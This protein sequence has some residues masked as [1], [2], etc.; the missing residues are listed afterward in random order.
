MPNNKQSAKRMRQDAIRR[1]ANRGRKSN[2]KTT[3]RRVTEAKEA[4]DEAAVKTAMNAA[5]KA[6][7][8]AAKAHSIHAN[9]AARRKALVARTA[10]LK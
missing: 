3:M 4:G 7:D 10:G 2:M 9:T 8:K 1:L 5:Y 6:I